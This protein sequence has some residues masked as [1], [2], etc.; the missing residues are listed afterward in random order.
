MKSSGNFRCQIR[1]LASLS[2][3]VTS[4]VHGQWNPIA[5]PQT[6]AAGI[7]NTVVGTGGGVA[8]FNVFADQLPLGPQ[9]ETIRTRVTAGQNQ[10]WRMFRAAV[11]I[12]RFYHGN[13]GRSFSVQAPQPN[14][15]TTPGFLALENAETDGIMIRANGDQ[16]PVNGFPLRLDGFASVGK[17]LAPGMQNMPSR[18]RWHMVDV[19]GVAVVEPWRPYY[20]NGVLFSGNN[21]MAYIGHRY[22]DAGNGTTPWNY[23]LDRSDLLISAGENDMTDANRQ[24]IRFTYTTT[25]SAGS[26][27]GAN[28]YNGLEF[29]QLWAE[30]NT[31][32]FFGLGDFT[33]G[34]LTPTQRFD[35]LD[36][37]MR[38]RQLPTDVPMASDKAMV[39]DNTGIVGWRPWPTAGLSDCDWETPNSTLKLLHTARLAPTAN[40]ICPEEDWRVS[41]GTLANVQSKLKVYGRTSVGGH[42]GAIQADFQSSGTGVGGSG[43]SASVTHE[44]AGT[45]ISGDAIGVLSSVTD[46]GYRGWALQGNITVAGSGAETMYGLGSRMTLNSGSNTSVAAYGTASNVIA[47]QNS[48][49]DRLY[50][51]YTT[52]TGAGSANSVSGVSSS[53]AVSGSGLSSSYGLDATSN[54]TG[55][56]T[57]TWNRGAEVASRGTGTITNSLGLDATADGLSETALTIGARGTAYGT[58]PSTTLLTVTGVHGES[59]GPVLLSRGA[60]GFAN[61][62]STG[63]NVTRIGVYG[64]VRPGSNS[65]ASD[66]A[67]NN[68]SVYGAFPGFGTAH[69]AGYFDGPV[70]AVGA[71]VNTGTFVIS[72]AELKTDVQVLDPQTA[73]LSSVIAHTYT[74][75]EEAQERLHL[76]EGPQFG[77]IAQEVEQVFP[78]LVTSIT[79]MPRLDSLNNVIAA[80]LTVKAVNYAGMVPLLITGHQQ[81]ESRLA[82]LEG[83]V[84]QLQ[85]QLAQVME[86]VTACCAGAGIGAGQRALTSANTSSA[87]EN[88]L[89]IVPNPVADRTELR[90]TVANEGHVR[91]EITDA[92]SRI[93]LKRE[94]GQRTA[95]SFVY[96]WDTTLLAPG[97]YICTLY[98]NDEFLVKKSVKLG[99]R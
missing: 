91:L 32:G 41:I 89:R 51:M 86:Q 95:G 52:V 11:E 15:P 72:D 73:D 94:E 5:N 82:S 3:L 97:T 37:F 1:A 21:D 42:A 39:V 77:M 27:A 63:A 71:V 40:P 96:E 17:R 7:I 87:L 79:F 36:G 34:N 80:P 22:L 20:R 70:S 64:Q 78:Q 92:S 14:D 10:Q 88:D 9:Q 74:Y 85:S 56:T 13:P 4:L 90:Y 55:G 18:A 57:L 76:P 29:M 35:M 98:I 50:G 99:T 45:P 12:G 61:T 47:Q 44:T 54:W 43:V 28:S 68:A 53:V 66:L 19:N 83:Q 67:T 46:A 58:H 26:L 65:L 6:M 81:Q 38:H 8:A 33:A 84:A 16:G 60:F 30:S 25:P 2:V 62:S 24:R 75:T 59:Q 49:V 69:W 23:T 31:Q 93:V 48:T